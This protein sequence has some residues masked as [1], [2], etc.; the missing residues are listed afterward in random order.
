MNVK[1]DRLTIRNFKGIQ[2]LS[3]QF[4]GKDAD[5]YGDNAT[6]K[7]TISDA[8]MW[9]LFGK[10]S[11]GKA[12]FGVK[13]AR[14]DGTTIRGVETSV[15]VELNVDGVQKSFKRT[16]TEKWTRK[17]GAAEAEFTGNEL[18][19]YINSVP[20]KKREYADEIDSILK[21]DIF[22][23]ITDPL[24]FNT[25][26]KWQDRRQMLID[27]CGDVSNYDIL[28]SDPQF[29]VLSK[30]LMNYPDIDMDEYRTMIQKKMRSVNK[31]LENIP[32]KIDEAERAKPDVSGLSESEI[33][34][35]IAALSAKIAA[36]D[37][38][39]AAIKNGAEI[40]NLKA[41]RNELVA[42]KNALKNSGM[43]AEETAA[44]EELR[45]ADDEFKKASHAATDMEYRLKSIDGDNRLARNKA[46]KDRLSAEWD[47]AFSQVFS[48]DTC[49][50][51]GQPLPEEQIETKKRQFNANKAARLEAIEAT[52][53]GIKNSDA[54]IVAEVEK[55]TDEYEAAKRQFDAAHTAYHDAE[56]R[57]KKEREKR[58]ARTAED[59]AK[60][61]DKIAGVD[62]SIDVL[63]RNSG[64]AIT[65]LQEEKRMFSVRREC[66]TADF[67]K[68]TM[69]E[70]QDNRIAE[71]MRDQ[72]SLAAEYAKL[73]NLL[74]LTDE[75]T[76]RKV[77][78]LNKRI[79][80]RFEYARFKLFETQI[81]EGIR[82]TCEVTYQGIPYADL[83]NAARIAVGI[84]I[85][86]TICGHYGVHAP[87]IIDNAESVN[88]IPH[89]DSQQ[90]RL[91]V[92][93]DPE[94][95]IEV[96]E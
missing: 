64:K 87:I 78:M 26:L 8:F 77:N 65:E 20:K 46:E 44:A 40:V 18:G 56:N 62:D 12:D 22:K 15:E 75:F 6:G 66:A 49:P 52:L 21:D 25:Q 57:L 90:I 60:I 91:Y 47:K 76:R 81:N 54:E 31:E 68:F 34:A 85:I 35:K 95:R 53:E 72:K 42:E 86:N 2:D 3:I 59:A 51:C 45:K 88:R 48:N 11:E 29:T 43:S 58:T 4:G 82:P 5:V 55:A 28:E 1:I 89:S 39:I 19:Y 79:N 10:N 93:K 24:Y 9:A 13:P 83:N 30:D 96:Q 67:L 74:Y 23:M 80:D 84:D 36:T 33:G 41:K 17:R 92:S 27:I 61:D 63:M 50:L 37:E 16:L 73:D 69:I 38:K 7:T 14:S 70:T 94:L 71:L 32:V